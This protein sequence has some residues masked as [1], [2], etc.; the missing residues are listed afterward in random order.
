MSTDA[1]TYPNLAQTTVRDAMQL[2]LFECGPDADTL[3]VAR[4]VASG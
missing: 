4:A 3:D 1:P 2:G